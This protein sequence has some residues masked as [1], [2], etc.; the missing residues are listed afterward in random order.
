MIE[1]DQKAFKSPKHKKALKCSKPKYIQSARCIYYLKN[2]KAISQ[3]NPNLDSRSIFKLAFEQWNNLDDA[4]KTPY[5]E[6]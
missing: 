3:Q 6:L 2:F 4:L 1:K 5:Y